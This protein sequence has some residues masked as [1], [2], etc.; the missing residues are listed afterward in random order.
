MSEF[1]FTQFWSWPGAH[2]GDLFKHCLEEWN[3]KFALKILQILEAIKDSILP[4]DAVEVQK[5][6]AECVQETGK[7][8]RLERSHFK[9]EFHEL[10]D[11][12]HLILR[13][14]QARLFGFKEFSAIHKSR[15]YRLAQEIA[16]NLLI[17]VKCGQASNIIELLRLENKESGKGKNI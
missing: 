10:L 11:N 1:I 5:I 8:S 13:I 3:C 15:C 6:F 14:R 9:M 7:L 16:G 4:E 12:Q 2:F 17:V